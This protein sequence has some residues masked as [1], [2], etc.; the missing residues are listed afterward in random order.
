VVLIALGLLFLMGQFDL[1]SG[2]AFEFGWPLILIGLGVWMV[3]RRMQDS[4][5]GPR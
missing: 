4:Q 3:V 5:G 2:R 1:F